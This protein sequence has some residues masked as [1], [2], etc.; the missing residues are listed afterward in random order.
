[1]S[2][3]QRGILWML[4][5]ALAYSLFTVF[6]KN[7]LEQLGTT[8]VLFWRFAVAMPVSWAVVAFRRIGGH[9]PRPFEVDWKPRV[10][11]GVSFGFMAYLAF[12]ALDRMSG[13]LYIV[14]CYTYPAMVALGAWLLGK[15]SSRHIWWA[16]GLTLLGIAFTVPEVVKGTDDAAL[17]GMLMTL[18]NAFIYACYILFSERLVTH[19][20]EARTSGDGFVAAAWGFTGAFV[21][22][23]FLSIIN[24]DLTAPSGGKYVS[25]MIAL[26]VVSTVVAGTTFFLG[27]RHLGPA[28]AALVAATEPVLTLIWAVT[29][30]DESLVPVQI[31]GAVL[32]IVGVVWS[33]RVPTATPPVPEVPAL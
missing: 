9:G 2:T 28:P 5:S 16:A 31:L 22:G 23:A 6:G 26:G 13:A 17:I 25:S 10:L 4:V 18:G 15:P 33:Q 8:D 24:G 27:V 29:I 1:V 11:A 30:L 7:V 12:A 32:V 20:D 19:E 3:K 14:I 21:V